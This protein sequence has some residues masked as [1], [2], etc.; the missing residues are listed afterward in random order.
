M[1]HRAT[2]HNIRRVHNADWRDRQLFSLWTWTRPLTVSWSY[3]FILLRH[4]NMGPRFIALVRLLYTELT[5]SIRVAGASSAQFP[6]Q[7]GTRQVCPLS[8]ILFALA[9][10]PLA[11]W[12]R[13]DALIR[14]FEWTPEI[15]DRLA[16]YADEI[17]FFLT[18]PHSSGPRILQVMH[19]FGVSI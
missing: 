18:D 14:G 1:L 16:L 4:I 19:I 8:P 2:R 3:M 15:A 6:I 13:K 17:L 11:T 12:V 9:I 5:A 10:E 7:R